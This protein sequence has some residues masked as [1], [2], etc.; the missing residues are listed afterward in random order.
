MKVVS[1][2]NTITFDDGTVVTQ[3]VPATGIV[4]TAP[5]IV[6]PPVVVVP[7]IVVPPTG[8]VV[9]VGDGK[10]GFT[11]DGNTTKY[12]AGTNIVIKPG[13]YKAGI[14]I[15]NLTGVTVTGTGVILQ[16]DGTNAT[17]YNVLTLSNLN[18]V[19][20]TGITTQNIGYFMGYINSKLVNVILSGLSF[21]NCAQGL[22]VSNIYKYDGTDS[23]ALLLNCKI[24]NCTFNGSSLGIGGGVNETDIIGL[25]RNLEIAN[26]VISNG[27]DFAYL[28]G[29]GFKIHDNSFT[30]LNKG[31][32]NDNRIL[33]LTGNGD[34]YNNTFNGN[35]GHA[36]ANIPVTFGL[37][38]KTSHF[39]NN[40]VTNSSRYAAFEFQ[41]QNSVNIPGKTTKADLVVDSNVVGN[42]DTDQWTG[43]PGTFIDN[44]QGYQVY[45]ASGQLVDGMGG[46]V[47]LTN[48]KGYNWFPVPTLPYLWNLAKP[49]VVSGN[50][51]TATK[52]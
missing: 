34:V 52:P 31:N 48:N 44:Y 51:Y 43:Y 32:T 33:K 22:Y 5:P 12:A 39:Y 45:N 21:I 23:S 4:T 18:T 41:E 42:I 36:A 10:S 37:T 14:T 35:E 15:Q 7:P 40:T 30:S 8:P 47:T 25:L 24:L 29:D 20:I 1:I 46:Q 2:Q 17:Y 26:C 13:T 19:T 16:G 49:S 50:T 11:I 28:L 38:P 9:N 3:L 27:G 6:I